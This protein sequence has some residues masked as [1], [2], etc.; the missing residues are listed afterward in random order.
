MEFKIE[1]DNLTEQIK[2]EGELNLNELLPLNFTFSER[3]ILQ[4]EEYNNIKSAADYL[5]ILGIIFRKWQEYKE[6]P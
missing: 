2:F 1:K 6:K 4:G 5:F 3:F